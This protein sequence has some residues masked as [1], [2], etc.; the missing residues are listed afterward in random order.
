[1]GDF[2]VC[3]TCHGKG[4]EPGMIQTRLAFTPGAP[5]TAAPVPCLTC[6]GHRVLVVH[7]WDTFAG[8]TREA[9]P[10][11]SMRKHFLAPSRN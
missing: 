5:M 11:E 8:K 9:K 2:M 10:F 3:P 1:M 4:S 6:K 7:T